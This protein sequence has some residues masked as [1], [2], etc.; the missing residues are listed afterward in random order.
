MKRQREIFHET[1]VAFKLEL[2]PCHWALKHDQNAKKKMIRWHLAVVL[3]NIFILNVFVS[4]CTWFIGE[5]E[6]T[7]TLNEKY[8]GKLRKI[9][10]KFKTKNKNANYKAMK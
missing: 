10:T 3:A 2:S 1:D 7:K 6:S 9:Y 5:T 8:R 4:N